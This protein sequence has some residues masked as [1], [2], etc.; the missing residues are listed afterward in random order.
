[1]AK[2]LTLVLAA[3]QATALAV[4]T[5][6][7]KRQSSGISSMLGSLLGSG[8]SSA[9]S[10]GVVD[11]ITASVTGG[12]GHFM[13]EEKATDSLTAFA[14]LLG[15]TR[16]APGGLGP[17]TATTMNAGYGTIPAPAGSVERQV[18][19][20]SRTDVPGAKTIKVR[21]GP[22]SIPSSK[23]KNMLGEMGMLSNFPH[24]NMA[25]P[26]EGDCTIMGMNAGLEYLNGTNANI[27]SGLWLHHMVLFNNGPGREDPP[28]ANRDV[29][30]PHVTVG[31]TS[32]SS[33]R[34]FASGNERTVGVW[35]DWGVKDAGYKLKKE[36]KFAA[37]VELMNENPEDKQVW[38]TMT[39]DIVDGHP[40]KDDIKIIWFDVRQ[41][42]TSE[43]NPPKGK[44]QFTLNYKWNATYDAEVIGSIEH[45]HDGG[46]RMTLELDGKPVC[47]SMTEYGT[48][49]EYIGMAAAPGAAAG[50]HNHGGAG[51]K[52][53]SEQKVCH[54]P[55]LAQ[56]S[57]KKGQLWNLNAYYDFDKNKGNA[58]A[59]GEWDEV[60]G[61][62]IMF[63]RVKGT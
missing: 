14:K 18:T 22:Y 48:K 55:T 8:S 38:M 11:L 50:G 45:L 16:T 32:H 12:L 53:I 56:K 41:C 43:V 28:C 36:D 46:N 7:N 13:G 62:A 1:M 34:I 25:K 44:N 10:G 57:V 15:A 17:W 27:D 20:K 6:L 39:Y 2:I 58:H 31:A 40:F 33:E 59:D 4:P 63:V 3:S 54:G 24:T 51:M 29:S 37:L 26:C 30:V 47:D 35:P 19:M 9:S 42:G 23:K 5:E 21:Y 60:M 49:P 52:H 61:I